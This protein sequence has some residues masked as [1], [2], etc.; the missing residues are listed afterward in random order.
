MG[1]DLMWKIVN[2]SVIGTSHQ[3]V[4][5]GLQD[6]NLV[7]HISDRS[8]SPWLCCLIADGAGSSRHGDIGAE[9]ALYRMRDYVG[10]YL[11]RTEKP[12]FTKDQ[13]LEG[14]QLVRAELT[15]TARVSKHSL[16]EYATTLA[17]AFIGD[18]AACFFQVGDG[19]TIAT[20]RAVSGI[21][22]WPEEGDFANSTYF[23]TDSDFEA[24]VQFCYATC[25]FDELAMF[26]DGLQRLALVYES[27]TVFLPF[28]EPMMAALRKVSTAEA[29]KLNEPLETFLSSSAVTART[30]DD[31]TL[32]L[33]TRIHDS[34]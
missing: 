15:E 24:H 19:A 26:T 10:D 11:K 12:V 33:A 29:T 27:R 1:T 7:A 13:I 21:V 17:G 9:T 2:K 14:I 22:F 30:D 6:C 20:S 4:G 8:G 5:A 32:V 31:K 16:R 3:V 23:I 34:F 28:F 18:R 25:R